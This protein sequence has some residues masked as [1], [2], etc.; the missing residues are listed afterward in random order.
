MTRGTDFAAARDC[1]IASGSLSD[2]TQCASTAIKTGYDAGKVRRALVRFPLEQLPAHMKVYDATMKLHLDGATS[3]ASAAIDV[4]RVTAGWGDGATWQRRTWNDQETWSSSGGDFGSKVWASRALSGKTPGY[5]DWNVTALVQQW[6]SGRWTNN[7]L[8]VKQQTE[9]VENVLTFAST[10][11][12]YARWPK[13]VIEYGGAQLEVQS[14]DANQSTGAAAYGYS[15]SASGLASQASP[16]EE[17]PSPSNGPCHGSFECRWSV[18]ARYRNGSVERAMPAPEPSTGTLPPGTSSFSKSFEGVTSEEITDLRLRVEPIGDYASL[19]DR[20]DTG[21]V[22]VSAP[23]VSGA[24][25]VG[26]DSWKRDASGTVSY[27]LTVEG[28]GAGQV[29]GPCHDTGCTWDVA[30][31][32]DDGTSKDYRMSLGGGSLPAGTWSFNVPVAAADVAAPPITHVQ[33]RLSCG[34][35]CLGSRESYTGDYVR[36]SDYMVDDVDLDSYA[37]MLGPALAAQ[38]H[39]FCDPLL[40]SIVNTNGNS[41]PDAFEACTTL[42]L[43]AATIAV[44]VKNLLDV[45]GVN[46]L[47]LLIHEWTLGGAEH[48][49]AD[50]H[51]DVEA[52]MADT[53]HALWTEGFPPDPNC[54]DPDDAAA[55]IESLP[56]QDHHIMTNKGEPV[57]GSWR[58]RFQQL[59]DELGISLDDPRNVIEKLEHRGRHTHRYHNWVYANASA[60]KRLANGSPSKFFELLNRWVRPVIERDPTILRA[61]YWDCRD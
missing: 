21:W 57:A 10:E 13:L 2:T 3:T 14:W 52:A 22:R 27:A 8:L 50:Y 36:V 53:T 15:L 24:V 58:A 42:V 40:F 44:I 19:N 18:D 35:G 41:L 47:D 23:Y 60:A 16:T 55:I 20:Y 9:T 48:S 49:P 51:S 33:A 5:K 11:A 30:A 1:F 31:Y 59:A 46:P 37:T 34:T 54:L 43:E 26:V 61:P 29:G 7:G 25:S 17:D 12:H 4:H 56:A 38:G 6:H 39:H 45:G 28:S 32:F